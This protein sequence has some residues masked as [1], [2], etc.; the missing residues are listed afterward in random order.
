MGSEST[1]GQRRLAAAGPL[2]AAMGVMAVI[3]SAGAATRT[4]GDHLAAVIAQHGWPCGT[5]SHYE[6]LPDSVYAATCSNGERYEVFLR[7][8]WQDN[9]APRQTHLKPLI[10]VAAAVDGLDA[11]DP[12][13]RRD[14]ADK[15][16]EL[17]PDASSAAS[18]LTR[19]VAGDRDA[20]VRAAA[21]TALGRLGVK[22]DAIALA[23]LR[24]TKDPDPEVRKQ[25]A[26]ALSILVGG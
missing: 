12:K 16:A 24:A 22:D 21:A 17:G 25:A 18:Q 14:A 4:L 26:L 9:E 19:S 2:V 23:L 3:G 5:I 11:T 10:D 8:G 7:P 15:L 6:P 20:S 13:V 1:I